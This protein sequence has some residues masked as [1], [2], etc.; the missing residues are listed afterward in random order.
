MLGKLRELT[1][2]RDGT[3]NV[4]ITVSDDFVNTFDALKDHPVTVEI[5]KAQKGRSKDANAMCWALCSDIGKA[6]TPPVDKEDIYRRAVRAVGVYSQVILTSWDFETV[7]KRWCSR[8]VGWFAEIADSSDVGR[9]WVH[10]YYG[11][12]VYTVDEMRLVLDWLMDE[13]RQMQIIIPL[14]KKEE[15][16]LL[17]RWGKH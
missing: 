16:K 12:S 11:T 4:T 5:K 2:N 6:L 10:L 9:V 14:S 13:A 1:I 15:E 17:E 7:R 8:G 3:Q